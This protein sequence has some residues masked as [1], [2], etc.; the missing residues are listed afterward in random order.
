[1]AKLTDDLPHPINGLEVRLDR[2]LKGMELLLARAGVSVPEAPVE[3][4]ESTPVKLREK[5]ARGKK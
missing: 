5:R 2:V 1:L 4:T 3:D